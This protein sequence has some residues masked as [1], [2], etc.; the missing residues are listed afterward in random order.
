MTALEMKVLN[1]PNMLFIHC[2]SQPQRHMGS[3]HLLDN[4]TADPNDCP[5]FANSNHLYLTAL[6]FISEFY[7][8]F[9]AL[10][11]KGTRN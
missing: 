1:W 6:K 4:V 7:K 3:F 2:T 8:S 5:S 11:T 10:S 9:C